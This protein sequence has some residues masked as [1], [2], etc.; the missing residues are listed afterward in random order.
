MEKELK[1]KKLRCNFCG[2]RFKKGGTK[3]RIKIEIV[4][5]F[6]GYLE[7]WSKKPDDYLQKK[8]EKS[9]EHTRDM[10]EKEIEEQ[11]YLKRELLACLK[12]REKFL[13]DFGNSISE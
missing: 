4:S 2:R 8:I 5:D 6:D 3:Y 9:L 10:T 13:K 11:I 12:C 1:D 7:D